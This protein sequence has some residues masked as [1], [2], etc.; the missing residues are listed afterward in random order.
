MIVKGIEILPELHA[1][2]KEKSQAFDLTLICDNLLNQSI[3]DAN[4]VFINATGYDNPTWENILA[5]LLTL[6]PKTRIII[7]SKKLP[8]PTFISR[9]QGMEKMS[10]GLTSTYIYEKIQ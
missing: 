10:W 2:A 1:L 6:K 8:E 9:Y 3:V 7:T 5:K 4:I